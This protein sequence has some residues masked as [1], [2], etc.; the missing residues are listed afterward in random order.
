MPTTASDGLQ[1]GAQAPDFSLAQPGADRTVRRVD[2]ESSPLVVA[3]LC[4][5][6]PYVVHVADAFAAFAKEAAE[7]GVRTVA[8]CSNDA[9]AYPD[10]DPSKMPGFAEAHGFEFPYLHDADQSV[11]RAYRAACTPDLF[12][13]ERRSP[14][15]LP[16]S[17]RRH[18]PGRREVHGR[19]PARRA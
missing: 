8:I 2:F 12:L 10:D 18:P 4:N 3:F 17:V 13:F 1:S 7:R 14:I 5:H 6:C 9:E 19:G 11:A 15:V 16:G